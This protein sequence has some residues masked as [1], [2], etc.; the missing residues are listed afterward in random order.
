MIRVNRE[1]SK[2][3]THSI[4]DIVLETDSSEKIILL[5]EP[6][7]DERTPG[8]DPVEMYGPDKKCEPCIYEI[9]TGRHDYGLLP[10]DMENAP[11]T[12]E[13]ILH[14]P[15]R[16]EDGPIEWIKYRFSSLFDDTDRHTILFRIDFLS[17]EGRKTYEGFYDDDVDFRIRF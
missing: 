11:P 14:L 6:K 4:I 12:T 7:E 3:E 13:A 2:T 10:S 15:Y 8:Y 16:V 1:E 9:D 17:R 5:P